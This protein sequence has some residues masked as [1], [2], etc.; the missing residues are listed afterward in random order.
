MK[1][2]SL[3]DIELN[4]RALVIGDCATNHIEGFTGRD[5]II[6]RQIQGGVGTEDEIANL[7]KPSAIMLFVSWANA[8][9]VIEDES[10]YNKRVNSHL[11]II[12]SLLAFDVPFLMIDRHGFL[13]RFASAEYLNGRAEVSY[14]QA[15]R[16]GWR[17]QNPF[18]QVQRRLKYR[19]EITKYLKHN[20]NYYDLAE[21]IGISTYR[22]ESGECKNN[23]VNIAPWHY[24]PDTYK[25]A[26][27]VLVSLLEKKNI[28][29][30]IQ[31]WE[32]GVLNLKTQPKKT[33]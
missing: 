16:E 17:P 8:L 21:Y 11:K 18:E 15:L 31:S 23:L 1:V 3:K 27:H 32:L 14:P 5:N 33:L 25:Y 24:D 7:S 19:Q 29:P 2:D 28:Q 30:L 9:S 13:D 26:A 12:K 22:H 6:S 20:E 4:D 10:D